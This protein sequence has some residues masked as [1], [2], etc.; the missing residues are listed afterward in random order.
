[1]TL[2]AII[3]TGDLIWGCI[4]MGLIALVVLGLACWGVIHPGV[5]P[6]EDKET[7]GGGQCTE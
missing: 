4:D 3:D 1:M 6:S 5:N 7:E 2:A